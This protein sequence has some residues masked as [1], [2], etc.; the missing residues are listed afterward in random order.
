MVKASEGSVC[1]SVCEI[2]HDSIVVFRAMAELVDVFGI[3]CESHYVVFFVPV[4]GI[5]EVCV[6][7][8]IFEGACDT[9]DK[10]IDWRDDLSFFV[11]VDV[12]REL[13][14]HVVFL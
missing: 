7:F 10:L 3:E 1:G 5:D 14:W 9:D 4:S 2:V 6:M 8:R 12:G 11:C 13:E